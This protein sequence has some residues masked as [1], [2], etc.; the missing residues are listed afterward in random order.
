[1]AHYLPI[2]KKILILNSLVEGNSICSTVRMTGVHKLTILR[3]LC[4]AGE[5]A[6]EILDREMVNLECKYIQVDEIWNFVFKKQKQCTEEEKRSGE[7]GDHLHV[8]R[9]G[10]PDKNC[11]LISYRKKKPALCTSNDEGF[12]I[13]N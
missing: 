1:M 4:E 5:R 8:C 2:E 13:Q 3:L 6:Q 12:T 10:Q 9:N 7:V 11:S